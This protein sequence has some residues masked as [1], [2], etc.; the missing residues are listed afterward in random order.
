MREKYLRKIVIFMISDSF[1]LFIAVQLRSRRHCALSVSIHKLI[2]IMVAST[3]DTDIW[4]TGLMWQELDL[5][6]DSNRNLSCLQGVISC[7]IQ[8][9]QKYDSV[10]RWKCT[11]CFLCWVSL[12]GVWASGEGKEGEGVVRRDDGEDDDE[13]SADRGGVLTVKSF[14]NNYIQNFWANQIARESGYMLFRN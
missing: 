12:R 7:P 8:L 10:M 3:S 5:L 4:V 2:I 6:S 13:E 9:K 11:T 14:G 1:H